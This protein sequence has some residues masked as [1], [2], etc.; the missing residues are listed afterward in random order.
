MVLK[1]QWVG[2][3]GYILRQFIYNNPLQILLIIYSLTLRVAADYV[4][5]VITYS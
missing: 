5:I 1:L 2:Q 3:T 4:K